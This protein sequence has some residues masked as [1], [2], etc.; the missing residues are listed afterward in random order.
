MVNDPIADFLTRVRNAIARQKKEFSVP[1]TNM[2]IA[3]AKIMKEEGY[4]N[5][6]E[7][8]KNSPQ[9]ELIIKL[10]YVNGQPAIRELKRVSKPGVR[11][12]MGYNQ[13]PRIKQGLG[14][15]IFSTPSGIMTGKK[16]K[17]AKV[18]GEFLCTIW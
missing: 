2:I 4:I 3:I 14:I 8:K 17:Q 10:K 7:V 11:R 12:Y 1:A 13:I 18:G 6:Y 16:A 5:N 15:S 9:D